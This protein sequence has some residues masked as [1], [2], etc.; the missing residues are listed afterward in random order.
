MEMEPVGASWENVLFAMLGSLI[1]NTNRDPKKKP[2]PFTLEDFM[3]L[4]EKPTIDRGSQLGKLKDR[5]ER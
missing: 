5:L 3:L 4:K 1:A 2:Q